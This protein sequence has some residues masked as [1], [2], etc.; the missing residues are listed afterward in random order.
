MARSVMAPAN[1]RFGTTTHVH[2]CWLGWPRTYCST[3]DRAVEFTTPPHRHPA[4]IAFD[5]AST[6][7][8]QC[9][10]GAG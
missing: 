7:T 9:M 2:S 1:G 6:L 4:A 10:V 3:T 5:K 8:I